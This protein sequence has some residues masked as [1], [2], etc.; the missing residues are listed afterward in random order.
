MEPH[1]FYQICNGR[2]L[3]RLQKFTRQ[4]LHTVMA[5]LAAAPNSDTLNQVNKDCICCRN[6][7][8]NAAKQQKSQFLDFL[9][10]QREVLQ[11]FV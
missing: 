3:C 9:A 5:R 4:C 6:V 11:S 2:D 7:N 8:I 1:L 10:Y